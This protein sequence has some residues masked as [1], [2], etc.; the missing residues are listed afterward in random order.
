MS[1]NSTYDGTLHSERRQQERSITPLETELID[2]YGEDRYS[3][4][5]RVTT[6]NKR[7][8]KRLTR[9]LKHVLQHL[10]T[11]KDDYIVVDGGSLVTVAHRTKRWFN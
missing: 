3:H 2:I 4:G 8:I 7:A 11:L 10:E 1:V 6:L 5:R 9:D